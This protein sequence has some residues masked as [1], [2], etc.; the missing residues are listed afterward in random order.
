VEG[1]IL[2]FSSTPS[3]QRIQLNHMLGSEPDLK[4]AV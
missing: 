3:P 2:S 4:M 1:Q